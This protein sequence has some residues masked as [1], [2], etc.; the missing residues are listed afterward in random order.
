MPNS[1]D[2]TAAMQVLVTQSSSD[3]TNHV[4]FDT[5]CLCTP[6]S[7]RCLEKKH[8]LLSSSTDFAGDTDFPELFV[9][10]HYARSGPGAGRLTL[11]DWFT[12]F[13]DANRHQIGKYNYQDLGSS[14]PVVPTK[15]EVVLG[16]GKDG[17]LY[18]TI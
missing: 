12:P 6:R 16:A 11:T 15:G 13:H 5:H 4:R 7:Q 10:L 14:A 2:R 8:S 1:P 9:K 3:T 18:A 17:F